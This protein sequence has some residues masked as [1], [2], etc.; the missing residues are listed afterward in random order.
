MIVVGGGAEGLKKIN[1]LLTQDCKIL[2]VSDSINSQIKKYVDSKKIE[3]Q[4]A[5]LDESDFL[6][7]HKPYLV[8][9]T[10]DDKNLN[11][12]IVAAARKLNCLAYA[13]DDPEISDFAHP[14]VI[15]IEDTI[16][17]AISTKGKSP[18][19]ARKVKMQAEKVFKEIITREDIELIKIQEIARQNAK[20]EI[21]TQIERKK[22]LYAVINDN[23]IK[24]LIKDNKLEIAQK[25][26]NQML[27]DWK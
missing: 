22:Y 2:L 10:T 4:K 12:K 27:R 15:N 26:A 9:A 16:Q 14:S 6:S 13:S 17:I 21:D 7:K 20:K 19:M 18:A 11:R 5:K 23:Q 8:M 3:F 25:R 1:S 24:Q